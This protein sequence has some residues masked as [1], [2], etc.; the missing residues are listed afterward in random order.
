MKEDVI[1][2]EGFTC[3]RWIKALAII[4]YAL[5]NRFYSGLILVLAMTLLLV[6]G[7]Q[8][9]GLW[10]N[11]IKEIKDNNT[12][13]VLNLVEIIF[14]LSLWVASI[15][16]GWRSTLDKFLSVTFHCGEVD[17]P[18]LADQFA[19]LISESDIRPLAQQIGR[20]KN[21]NNALDLDSTDYKF[22]KTL[23]FDQNKVVS[24]EPFWHYEV[25]VS[26]RNPPQKQQ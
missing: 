19:L 26:L 23:S 11:F 20:Q 16:T 3:Y 7:F 13:T 17:F 8:V 22:K 4:K 5:A 1:S 10:S 9:Q 12:G 18:H 21:N 25:T 6:A 2:L 14:I 24:D 15:I